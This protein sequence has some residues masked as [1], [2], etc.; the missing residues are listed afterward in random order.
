MFNRML[1]E[2][3]KSW[4][5]LPE[6]RL[7]PISAFFGAN[8]SG[9]TSLLQLL[10]LLKQTSISTDRTQPL[11]LGDDRSLIEL[12]GF[13]DLIFEHDIER[14]LAI[15]VA[16]SMPDPLIVLDPST[17][18]RELFKAEE[19]D[20]RTT[21]TSAPR[22]GMEVDH[23]AYEAAGNVITMRRSARKHGRRESEYE[24]TARVNDRD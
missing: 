4:R 1:A 19:L 9:K 8:S 17:E 13:R 12:G 16:W 20:F 10:L 15:D 6:T 24:L 11:Q 7:A 2:N 23:F 22:G 3:F 21:I 18:G 5:H 14:D